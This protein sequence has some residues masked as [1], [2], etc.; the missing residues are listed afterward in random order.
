M[1]LRPP[2]GPCAFLHELRA[3]TAVAPDLDAIEG[4]DGIVVTYRELSRRVD[5]LAARLRTLGVGPGSLVALELPRSTEF[6][7]GLLASWSLGAAWMPLD[8]SWPAGPGSRRARCI[9]VAGPSVIVGANGIEVRGGIGAREPQPADPRERL[10]YV[11]FTSGS[12]GEPKGVEV[13][14]RGLVSMLRAQIEAFGV[15]P[16]MR[17]AWLLSPVFDASISDIG[18]ALLAGATLV[19]A[20]D[21]GAANDPTVLVDWLDARTIEYADVPPRVLPLLSS[22]RWPWA[23]RSVVVGGEVTPQVHLERAARHARV[24]VVY[25][26]TEATVCTSLVAVDGGMHEGSIGRPLPGVEYHV[27]YTPDDAPKDS[28]LQD[29]GELWIAGEAL[30][31]GYRGRPALTEAAF[32]EWGGARWYR[33]GDLVR[34][35]ADGTFT[36]AGR[37]DRQVKYGGRRLELGEIEVALGSI[38]GVRGAVVALEGVGPRA[39]LV[40]HVESDCDVDELR[41]AA[42]E[43]L[44]RWMLPRRWERHAAL[45]RT[46]SG[47]PI[48]RGAVHAT[49]AVTPGLDDVLTLLFTRVLPVDERRRIGPDTDF[50]EVGGDSLGVLDLLVHAEECG[51]VLAP[52]SVSEH[53]TPRRIA[54]ALSASQGDLE[55]HTSADLL[56]EARSL[57]ATAFEVAPARVSAETRGPLRCV[58]VTG[59]TGFLGS[60][61]AAA[62]LDSS[63]VRVLALVRATDPDAGHARLAAAVTPFLADP[64]RIARASVVTGDLTA[65]D[66]L[67]LD[68]EGLAVLHL[69]A[70]VDLTCPLEAL[71][72]TDVA[73]TLAVLRA[74]RRWGNV[75]VT[76]ASTLAVFAFAERSWSRCGEEPLTRD[77]AAVVHGGYA[78]A[79]WL[80]EALG[81]EAA[82]AGVPVRVLRYG[83]LAATEPD[84]A[85]NRGRQDWWREVMRALGRVGA[86]PAGNG[87]DGAWC[88]LTPVEFAA[89]ATAELVLNAPWQRSLDFLHVTRGRAVTAQELCDA[90]VAVEPTTRRLPAQAFFAELARSPGTAAST[91]ALAR[92]RPGALLRKPLDLFAATGLDF[93]SARCA[94]ALCGAGVDPDTFDVDVEAAVREALR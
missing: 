74:A 66:A 41:R 84:R 70:S 60:R 18:V 58:L 89:R 67:E 48:V 33:T 54:A 11:V 61:V 34:R 4:P 40:A 79:K 81:A 1:Q 86:V 68:G 59:A 55:R 91:L 78:A 49:G 25:G 83:L 42:A 94:A 37:V 76:L 12:S 8:P 5:G 53:R 28:G 51:L 20:P 90:L 82:R 24:T 72:G 21:A 73:G 7:V 80:V 13:L 6:V 87:L 32:G 47:K 39:E 52:R 71:R 29:V 46:A 35:E 30:A 69:A 10:A 9:S 43:L 27:W 15:T 22:V 23:L 17:C 31:R 64:A 44:P 56:R 88:D 62:L 92:L 26:P 57:A 14:H 2:D 63:D 50:F 3:R 45:P 38:R 75:P 19:I 93:E 65:L 36:F 85:P 77:P 16:H